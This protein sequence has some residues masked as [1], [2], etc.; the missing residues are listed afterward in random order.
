MTLQRWSDYHTW[1]V[2]PKA[3]LIAQLHLTATANSA[4][5]AAA[6]PD[7]ADYIV[8]REAIEDAALAMPH[9]VA[10]QFLAA[11]Y[12]LDDAQGAHLLTAI[13]RVRL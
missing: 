2:S 1:P 9:T 5:L 12:R 6:E 4:L 11:V 13:R 8:P 7:G 3:M 10:A